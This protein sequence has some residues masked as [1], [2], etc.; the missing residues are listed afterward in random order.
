MGSVNCYLIKTDAGFVLIDSGG[1]NNRKELL[2]HLENAGCQPGMLKMILLT[3]GDFDHTGNAA[4]L[5]EMFEGKIAMHAGDLGMVEQG[6]MFFNRNQPNI[7]I[8]SLLPV[9]SRFGKSQRFSPDLLVNDGD[10]LSS[11]GF[12]ARVISIPGHSKGSI[13]ILTENADLFCGDLLENTKEPAL[14]SLTDDMPA[15]TAS[16]Q[17]L[18][19]IN[20]GMVYPGHGQ[21]FPMQQFKDK[22]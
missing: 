14:G 22:S 5:R 6:D 13:A 21:P 3:H 15:A 16:L 9:V 7:I 2:N 1:S 18:E 19:T 12:E 4:Y 17:K 11:Y 10:D 8:R 20:I